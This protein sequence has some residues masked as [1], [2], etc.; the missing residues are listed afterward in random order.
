MRIQN[1][2]QAP[3]YKRA[4]GELQLL[5]G[6][7]PGMMRTEKADLKILRIEPGLETSH[8]YHL[9]RESIFHVMSGKVLL[10]SSQAQIEREL[11][12]GDTFI[13]E[14]C[15][16]HVLKNVGTQEAVILEIESPPHASTDKIPYGGIRQDTI[17]P[18]RPLGRFWHP[19]GRVK[20]KI[21]GVKNLD[22]ALECKRLGVDAIGIHAVGPKGIRQ[23]LGDSGWLLNV[24]QE[25]SVFLLTDT[26]ELG[27]LH[28]LIAR[29]G[30]DTIQV[31]GPQ[32]ATG[33]AETVEYVR[34][35]GRHVVRTLSAKQGTIRSA[36]LAQIS[37]AQ[38]KFDSLLIDAATYGGTGQEHDWDLTESV[39]SEIKVPL[40]IAGGLSS[41][42]CAEA[43]K[44]MRPYGI[45]V[46][47]RVE[48]HFPLSGGRRLSA[49]CFDAIKSLVET[50]HGMSLP[51]DQ[52]NHLTTLK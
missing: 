25:L 21:C 32:S 16:D 50:V 40:I 29:T 14:P 26:R 20:V 6:N 35:A 49:K 8:H 22:T 34:N 45:D 47:S 51:G 38:C 12:A 19:D 37:E 17:I 15:E 23:V 5:C 43:I 36:L 4:Y 42:N 1:S 52:S 28:E 2:S 9:E 48:K 27:I 46:E 13:V 39:R 30:C 41:S 18:N 7:T 3:I 24:P 11:T 44:R 31:Q 33:L 10:R